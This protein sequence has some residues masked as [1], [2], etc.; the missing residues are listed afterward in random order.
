[1]LL[2]RDSAV[3]G[4]TLEEIERRKIPLPRRKTQSLLASDNPNTR[5]LALD[6]LMR[7]PDVSDL[8]YLNP[9]LEDENAAV[10]ARANAYAESLSEK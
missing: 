5:W 3:V 4:A 2:H 1:M 6:W 8:P 10:R 7:R 9:L